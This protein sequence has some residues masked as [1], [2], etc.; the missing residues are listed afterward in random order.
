VINAL[1]K[2]TGSNDLISMRTRAGVKRPFTFVRAIQQDAEQRLRRTEQELQERKRATEQKIQELQAQ[3]QDS[4][5]LILSP[6]QEQEIERFREEL[7]LVRKELRSVQHELNK[8]IESLERWLKFVN[9]GLVPLL[10]GFLGLV[11]SVRRGRRT[12][13]PTSRSDTA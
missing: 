12:N 2:L 10:I 1:D 9:I 3:K 11:I 13:P 5:A 4:S 6:E 7:V 8:N